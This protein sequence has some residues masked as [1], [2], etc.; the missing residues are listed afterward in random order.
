[1]VSVYFSLI[2]RNRLADVLKI[3]LGSIEENQKFKSEYLDRY[4]RNWRNKPIPDWEQTKSYDARYMF[5]FIPSI[6][7]MKESLGVMDA[8]YKQMLEALVDALQ[9]TRVA[10]DRKQGPFITYDDEAIEL[11]LDPLNQL[12]QGFSDLGKSLDFSLS[13]E[14]YRENALMALLSK[15]RNYDRDNQKKEYMISIRTKLNHALHRIDEDDDLE[16][17][18]AELL[19]MIVKICVDRVK[20]VDA[21]L[22]RET[23]LDFVKGQV[24]DYA[25]S[26]ND[27]GLRTLA[28]NLSRV[29]LPVSA[30]KLM[31][32]MESAVSAVNNFSVETERPSLS[33]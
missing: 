14:Q 15:D 9:K 3:L 29:D 19:Q 21:D 22:Y 23:L 17:N 1:M 8:S 7:L 13:H 33:M 28:D 30:E 31:Q 27:A 12:I 5:E 16:K 20:E 4:D 32:V 6:E 2:Q 18:P 11:V 24:S 10:A 25:K 26:F